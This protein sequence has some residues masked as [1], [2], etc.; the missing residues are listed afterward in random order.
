MFS[1][2]NGVLNIIGCTFDRN[3]SHGFTMSTGNVGVIFGNIFSNNGGYGISASN[4]AA[5]CFIDY[6][7]Y[8][9]NTSGAVTGL[10]QG[11]HDVLVTDGDPLTDSTN[12][13]V[14]LNSTAL[15]GALLRGS[16]NMI[17]DTGVV[18]NVDYSD[19]GALQHQDSGGGST[20]RLFP[21]FD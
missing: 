15:R 5:N 9:N 13:D 3:S 2:G 8:Y 20:I 1:C 17:S 18:A 4:I 21:I 6:N 19:F 12:G 14:R 11:P 16:L 7:A 10:A